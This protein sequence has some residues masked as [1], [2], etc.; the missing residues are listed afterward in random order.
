MLL[1]EI[2]PL[3]K[4]VAILEMLILIALFA[5]VGWLLGRWTTRAKI[6]SLREALILQEA[7]LDE[8]QRLSSSSVKQVEHDRMSG[9]LFSEN[10]KVIEGIGPQIEHVLKNAGITNLNLLSQS[11]FR[12]LSSILEKAG[13]KYQMHDP[14]TWPEQAALARDGMWDKLANLQEKLTGG[15]QS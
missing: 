6:R 15:R 8:C 12:T 13:S 14:T 9:N 5:I 11:S 10:L 1:L 2:N 4:T 3:S 7:D